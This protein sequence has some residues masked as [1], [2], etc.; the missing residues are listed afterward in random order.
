LDRERSGM[1]E[2]RATIASVEVIVDPAGALW[3]AESRTLVVADLHL[4]KAS[5]F[6]RRGMFL[7]PY[8]TAAT[9]LSLTAL[10][11]RRNPRRVVSLGDSFHDKEGH[12]RL[13]EADRAR[14]ASLQRGRDWIW[15][16]GNHDPELP[17]NSGGDVVAELRLDGL[18]FRHEPR[19][20]EARGEI[21]GHLHPAAKVRGR[22]GSVRRR[23]FATDGTRMVLPAFGVLAGGLNVLDRA[24]QPLFTAGMLRAFL[25]GDGCLFPIAGA[26]LSPD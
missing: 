8:D 15:I 22:Q 16:S 13:L 5:A 11:L 1:G 19:T 4:E 26:A 25:I 14:L 21:A 18:V 12:G 9:L 3:L 7:P 17:A 10:V 20:G 24:F 6:A 2:M 23:A